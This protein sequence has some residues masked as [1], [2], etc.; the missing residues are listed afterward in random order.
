MLRDCINVDGNCWVVLAVAE[1]LGLPA[2]QDVGLRESLSSFSTTSGLGEFLLLSEESLLLVIRS[3]YVQAKEVEIF[4]AAV[5]WLSHNVRGV[6]DN[7][8]HWVPPLGNGIKGLIA[9]EIEERVMR[10][11]RFGVMSSQD[12]NNIQGHPYVACSGQVSSLIEEALGHPHC[13]DLSQVQ[14]GKL[15]RNPTTHCC[16]RLNWWGLCP[17]LTLNRGELNKGGGGDRWGEI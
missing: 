7:G 4:K 3:A 6:S 2:L 9:D 16:P 11:I 14:R 1:Q 10:A 12:I 8:T 17:I 5:A 13:Q 15:R